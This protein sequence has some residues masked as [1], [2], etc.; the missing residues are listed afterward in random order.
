MEVF[1]PVLAVSA[2][3]TEDAAV[4]QVRGR[5]QPVFSTSVRALT[6]WRF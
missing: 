6:F 4:Q 3:D 1:G 2:F 5:Y